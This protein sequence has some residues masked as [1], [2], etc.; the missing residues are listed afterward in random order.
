MFH[1]EDGVMPA[2][3]VLDI[4]ILR[5]TVG[6]PL[7]DIAP[8]PPNTTLPVLEK[9]V[10]RFMEASAAGVKLRVPLLVIVPLFTT[11]PIMLW[12]EGPPLNDAPLATVSV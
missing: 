5:K 8:A 3:L 4:K 1:T 7:K 10:P 11:S 12:V 2:A 9:L 6:V